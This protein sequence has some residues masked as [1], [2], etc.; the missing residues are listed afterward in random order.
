MGAGKASDS[1]APHGDAPDRS[2]QRD[3]ESGFSYVEVLVAI[4]IVGV[5]VIAALVG[6]PPP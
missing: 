3:D 2:T 5:T 1:G 6:L 4:V